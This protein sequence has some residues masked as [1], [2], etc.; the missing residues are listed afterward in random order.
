MEELL[1]QRTPSQPGGVGVSWTGSSWGARLMGWIHSSGGVESKRTSLGW[2]G[3]YLTPSPSRHTL[4]SRSATPSHARQLQAAARSFV[5]S[6]RFGVTS[7]AFTV[8]PPKGANLESRFRKAASKAT[9][10]GE[11]RMPRLLAAAWCHTAQYPVAVRPGLTGGPLSRSSSSSR[12]RPTCTLPALGAQVP[13]SWSSPSCRRMAASER[14]CR[15]YSG[16][17]ARRRPKPL[18]LG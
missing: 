16:A 1:G 4:L 5:Y 17:V 18:L 3:P 6:V 14:R 9:P 12:S 15:L 13:W 10:A 8:L 11:C 2:V 7:S